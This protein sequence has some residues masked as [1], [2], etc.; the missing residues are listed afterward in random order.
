MHISGQ[1]YLQTTCVQALDENLTELFK[2]NSSEFEARTGKIYLTAKK[3]H[4][5]VILLLLIY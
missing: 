5:N 2:Q 3:S 1:G 4:V